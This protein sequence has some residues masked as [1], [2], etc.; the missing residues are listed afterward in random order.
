M[1]PANHGIESTS[2]CACDIG[3]AL[4]TETSP[5]TEPAADTTPPVQEDGKAV[6]PAHTEQSKEVKQD[7]C[8]AEH[9]GDDDDDEDD[10]NDADE[11]SS[12]PSVLQEDTGAEEMEVT[13]WSEKGVGQL[14]LLVP[15]SSVV[16]SVQ[17]GIA[18]STAVP[19]LV[20]R[21]E[22]VGRLILNEPLRPTTAPAER[23]SDT[24]IRLVV[25][26]A[27]SEASQP[28]VQ[29]YLFRVKTAAE[30]DALICQI[31]NS[32]PSS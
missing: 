7:G 19:R 28:Q 2:A 11:E 9:E 22:H 31:N 27:Q 1:P 20:M 5:K 8:G 6:D 25:V 18:G 17:G 21:V 24:S 13:R 29:S 26:S 12:K 10:D 3:G 32:I 4:S 14:R 16:G 23:V 15:K 30:A